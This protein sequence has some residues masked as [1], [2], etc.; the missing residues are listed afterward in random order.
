MTH[1]G[2]DCGACVSTGPSGASS[3][4]PRACGR[5]CRRRRRK[6]V[7]LPA[8]CAT[9]PADAG[10]RGWSPATGARPA[11][12]PATPAGRK[13]QLG[14]GPRSDQASWRN[15]LDEPDRRP[16]PTEIPSPR[17]HIERPRRAPSRHA[18]S[19]CCSP[20]PAPAAKTTHPLRRTHAQ[21][22]TRLAARLVRSSSPQSR[23][24]R[25]LPSTRQALDRTRA[26]RGETSDMFLGGTRLPCAASRQLALERDRRGAQ[27]D[28]ARSRC[29]GADGLVP[30][31]A[32][33]L[34]HESEDLRDAAATALAILRHKPRSRA[35]SAWSSS[36]AA[37]RRRVRR[38]YL[39][40]RRA[41]GRR[42]DAAPSQHVERR[43]AA[44]ARAAGAC[45][46]SIPCARRRSCGAR[47]RTRSRRATPRSRLAWVQDRCARL[48]AADGRGRRC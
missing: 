36:G 19:R 37:G 38:G 16:G 22:A 8:L 6:P 12:V 15:R 2:K 18:L 5:R 44:R 14:P 17:A 7:R 11:A 35:V 43:T 9:S 29:S 26:W 1:V 20:R 30:R 45:S 24:A 34:E 41:G 13:S 3:T 42:A 10:S 33:L 32:G 47:P 23:L 48:P 31:A 40:H 27:A 21:P 25:S 46:A 28:A 4:S 39:G